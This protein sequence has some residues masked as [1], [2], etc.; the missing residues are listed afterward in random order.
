MSKKYSIVG[1][2]NAIVDLLCFVEDKFLQEHNLTKGGMFL[3]DENNAAKFSSLEYNKISSGGSVANSIASLAMFDCKTAFIGKVGNDKSGEIFFEDLKKMGSNFYCKNKA[4]SGSTAKSFVLITPDGERTMC[5]YLGCASQIESEID[6]DV[7]KDSKVLYIEGYLW[8]EEKTILAIRNAITIAKDNNV[9]VA[10]SLSDAFCVTRHKADF[11]GLAE[12]IDIMFANE[13]EISV[14]IG[15]DFSDN[16]YKKVVD[17]INHFNS[18]LIIAMTVQEK[19][20]V[21]FE[22]TK[23]IHQV[24]TTKIDK[25]VD[26]TG[27]GDAFAAGFLYGIDSGLNLEQSA[28][29]GNVLAGRIILQVGARLISKQD[30]IIPNNFG[31]KK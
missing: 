30:F 2:G 10:F 25:V 21:I 19:G 31:P 14:L 9:K 8:D 24:P 5:T 17:Y 27:A 18:N 4:K 1:I 23:N 26:S 16:N 12:N 13:T 11:R 22:G 20:S 3:V 15:E 7:I 29:F 28:E 6:E